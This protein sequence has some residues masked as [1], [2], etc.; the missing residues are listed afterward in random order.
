MA[1]ADIQIRKNTTFSLNA[2][3]NDN[4]KRL[5]IGC[6]NPTTG[7]IMRPYLTIDSSEISI[8]CNVR[9]AFDR[10]YS[11][12]IR[13]ENDIQ[14]MILRDTEVKIILRSNGQEFI[15]PTNSAALTNFGDMSHGYAVRP[16]SIEGDSAAL[17]YVSMGTSVR[18]IGCDTWVFGDSW[19]TPSSSRW[20][21]QLSALGI[22]NF[23]VNGFA[24]A[25]SRVVIEGFRNLMSIRQ[26]KRVVWLM[27][28]NDKDP[29]ASSINTS[30]LTCVQEVIATCDKYDV[31][32]ILATIP[33][34]PSSDANGRRYMSAKNNWVRNS[35]RRY[36]DQEKALGADEEGNWSNPN[37][38][39]SGT[40]KVHTSSIGAKVLAAQFLADI[41]ELGYTK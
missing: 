26:P 38:Y 27:G 33:N 12:G 18:N 5:V 14:V 9:E 8:Y 10:T 22:D 16:V 11:H 25:Q 37:Y 34:V 4:F 36:V 13:V 30:W 19:T 20:T 28:M 21:G 40:D 6:H 35:G 41:P 15:V 32:V 31:E 24:G 1:L 3:I 29:S 23:L 2:T 39:S 7:A 17:T